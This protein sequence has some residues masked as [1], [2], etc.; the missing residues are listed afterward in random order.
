MRRVIASEQNRSGESGPGFSGEGVSSGRGDAPHDDSREREGGLLSQWRTML[1]IVGSIPFAFLGVGIYRAWLATFFRYEAFPTIGFAD[2]AVFEGAI[3]VVSFALAFSARRVVPLWSNR[4]ASIATAVSLVGGSALIVLDCFALQTGA[5]KLAG[6]VLAGGGLGSLILMW[7]EF[8]GSLNPMRVALYHALAIMVGC[9]IKWVFMGLSAPYLAFLA[10]VLPLVSLA[11]VRS[12]MK[13][14][15]ERDLPHKYDKAEGGAAFPWKP[16]LLMSACTFACGFGTLPMQTLGPGNTLGVLLVTVLVVI[17]VLSESKWF[18]FD[19][20]YQLAFPL[21][22]IAFLFVA[23]SVGANSVVMAACYDAG[24]TMLSM[25]MMLVLSNITYRFGISAVWINGIERGIRYLVEIAG[26]ALSATLPL[27]ASSSV[28]SGIY[29]GI[30]LVMI[31]VFVVVFFTERGLS[32]KWGVSLH[33]G[34][35]IDG[36]M[37][38]SR[39]AMRVSDVSKEHNLTPREEE[40]LQLLARRE[41][42]SQIEKN[43][44]VA[45]GTLKAHISHIYRKLGVH[46]REELFEMLEEDSPS[47]EDDGGVSAVLPRG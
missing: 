26:W 4:T 24:Y 28:V 7:A 42:P 38:S 32:A 36:A 45:H 25:F 18:N 40:V 30:A 13:R 37:S 39:L 35:G 8:Y 5:V 43:L 3:A 14:L 19:T 20:I 33:G 9:A 31:V 22:I 27:L 10:I 23:P 11:Q 12:S 44:Y 16:V 6:L 17:G 47:R 41:S 21:S 34:G 2:Y 29:T 46:S 1:K 15:P